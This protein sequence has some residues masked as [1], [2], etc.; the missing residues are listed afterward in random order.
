MI[1][2]IIDRD[3]FRMEGLLGFYP[4]NSVGDDIYVYENDVLPRPPQPDRVF[5]GLRQ[6]VIF[7]SMIILINIF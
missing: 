7:F 4:A 5:Y 1:K 3:L 6:Q 2:E